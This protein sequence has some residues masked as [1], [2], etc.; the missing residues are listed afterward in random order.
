MEKVR[1]S[2]LKYIEKNSRVDLKEL[3]ILI[4]SDEITVVNELAG[5]EQE[6]IIKGFH[7][8]IDWSRTGVERVTALIEVR[9]TPTRGEGFD[10]LAK[11]ICK[12]PEVTSAYLISGAYDL[13]ITL[14]GKTLL[15]ISTF[16]SER[17]SPME[18][19]MSTATHFIL[20]K[21]KDYGITMFSSE[22][23]ERM[24]VTP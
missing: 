19:V 22:K 16:V 13:L 5:M 20:K 3:A 1:K 11:R 24:P 10:K 7:T 17:L 6:G 21:Y 12:Y 18:D 15:E 9:V 8:L 23:A 14:E 4:G 2:I